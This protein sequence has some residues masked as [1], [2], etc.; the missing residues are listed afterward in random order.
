[1]AVIGAVLALGACGGGGGGGS[2]SSGTA[3]A[4]VAPVVAP[5]TTPLVL[6]A[7]ANAPAL[8][9]D[10]A[11]D[12]LNWF[13]FRRQQMGL[14]A[15]TRDSLI[16]NAAQ[17]HSNYQRLN[18][19]ITHEEVSGRPGFTGVDLYDSSVPTT[20]M[21]TV[22]PDRL[23]AAGYRFTQSRFAYGEVISATTDGSGFNAAEDLIAAIYHRFVI[24]EPMF[25]EAGSGS[26][27]AAGGYNYFTTD[28]AANGLGAGL[29]SGGLL[30]YPTSGQINVPTIFYS[31]RESPDPIPGRNE[32]GYP[33]SVHADITATVTVKTFT[34][35]PRGGSV[36]AAFT[37]SNAVD[38]HTPLSA[39]AIIP[40][41]V[42]AAK[43]TYDVQFSGTV[44][45]AA[46]TRNWSF[47]TQ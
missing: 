7:E 14:T 1:M 46:V 38:A 35:Q 2:A 27:T 22:A 5:V 6:A 45:G 28:F 3:A 16:D 40:V 25:R 34:I 42:L 17:A 37:L 47:T 24:F 43:T 10:T 19:L 23:R 12:G 30:G 26:A 21:P 31:D 29:G 13:N 32:V 20:A 11:T 4:V 8:S 44:D 18:N 36:L 15:L 9:N 33:V 39:A 41:A